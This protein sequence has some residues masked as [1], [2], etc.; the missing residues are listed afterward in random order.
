MDKQINLGTFNESVSIRFDRMVKLESDSVGFE[1]TRKQLF[2]KM[3]SELEE[4]Y[5]NG[6]IG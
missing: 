6:E 4:K 3:L 2:L 5:E 1:M